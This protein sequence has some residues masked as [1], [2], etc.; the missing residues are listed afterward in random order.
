MF[1]TST[2]GSISYV[3]AK[4][5]SCFATVAG[6]TSSYL[7]I[8][9]WISPH[10]LRINLWQRSGDWRRPAGDL[11]HRQG[12]TASPSCTRCVK[13]ELTCAVCE[14][15][16]EKR[17]RV[18]HIQAVEQ[19]APPRGRGAGPPENPEGP[20]AGVP[21]PLPHPLALRLSVSS[22]A[23]KLSSLLFYLHNELIDLLY[24]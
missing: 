12:R 18:R 9:G 20:E 2:Y 10:R 5:L 6:E 23:T 3:F 15:G 4:Q 11:R 24:L 14:P 16:P 7:G 1:A 13:L 19:P 17:G 8:G 21:G 22:T